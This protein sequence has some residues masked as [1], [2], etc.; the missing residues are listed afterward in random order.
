MSIEQVVNVVE[1][2]IHKLR[3]METLYR[4][5][6]DEVNKLQYTRQSLVN[7]IEARKHKI[8]LL[9]KTAFSIEL[10]CKRKEQQ[11]QAFTDKKNRLEKWITNVLNGEG[12]TKL[13]QIVKESVKAVL[14]DNKILISISFAA[15]IQTI[16]NDP[17]M[18]NLIHKIATTNDGQQHKDDNN[19]NAIK[20]LE[21][22]KNSLS[23]LAEH[24]ENLVEA[25]TNNAVANTSPNPTLS[26]SSS[27]FPSS[28]DQ[29]DIYRRE[30]PETY[31]NDNDDNK[32]DIAD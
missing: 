6:K 29:S 31:Y 23:D 4:Q 13:M 28:F 3:Y 25:L 26:S 19:N 21:V 9:D 27:A 15:L 14:S 5:I 12:Y 30:E 7:D 18:T 11:V 16:K 24:Y 10:D 32:L 20:Y 8:S 1:I 2:A 17:Q 22:N